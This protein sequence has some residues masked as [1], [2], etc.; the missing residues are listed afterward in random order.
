MKKTIPKFKTETEERRFWQQHDSS[1]YLDWS[2]AEE[3]V[4]PKLKP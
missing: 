2:E 1:E 3:I 4:L